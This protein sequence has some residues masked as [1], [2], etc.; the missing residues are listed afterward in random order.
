MVAKDKFKILL[1]NYQS[2][3]L[4]AERY[5]YNFG[6]AA[7]LKFHQPLI[8]G[9][10]QT[11]VICYEGGRPVGRK[12]LGYTGRTFLFL[13]KFFPSLYFLVDFQVIAECVCAGIFCGRGKFDLCIS[14]HLC[15]AIAGYILKKLGK[16]KRTILYITDYYVN[17][18][19]CKSAISKFYNFLYKKL[20]KFL[21]ADCDGLWL[22]SPYLLQAPYLS[23]LLQVTPKPVFAFETAGCEDLQI[24]IT[25]I[26]YSRDIAFLGN[27]GLHHGI[28]LAVGALKEL[29]KSFPDVKLKIIGTGPEEDN[30]RV[31]VKKNGLEQNVIFYGYIE[32]RKKVYEIL[33]GC[34]I[35][36]ATYK[37]SSEF[38][39]NK[40]LDPG[41]ARMYMAVGLP[42]VINK[43][44][45]F[46]E[47]V[48]KCRAGFVIDYNT[49]QLINVLSKF[50]RDSVLIRQFRSSMF[51]VARKYNYE[52]IMQEAMDYTFGNIKI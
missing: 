46:A 44:P 2:S 37:P 5:F 51:N 43:G 8:K 15:T 29:A 50:L 48:E 35:G 36:L 23:S 40:Y 41:K 42:V 7:I 47:I 32:D 45:Y 39:V 1:F 4:E 30:I 27:L 21:V 33:S 13:L 14:R 11:E 52:K 10:P 9:C 28:E 19:G 31:L 38:E 34:A 17:D 20:L 12:A 3:I 6:Y 16:V 25:Q 18:A 22:I 24:D 49:G 26:A